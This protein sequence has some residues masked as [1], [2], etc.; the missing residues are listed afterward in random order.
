[1]EHIEVSRKPQGNTVRITIRGSD[2]DRERLV[3]AAAERGIS[4]AGD[5]DD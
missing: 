5:D 2:Q 1:V 4:A 3:T